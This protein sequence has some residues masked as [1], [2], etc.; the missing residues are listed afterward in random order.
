METPFDEFIGFGGAI[1]ERQARLGGKPWIYGNLRLRSHDAGQA[2]TLHLPARQMDA[3]GQRR[4]LFPR[5][6]SVAPAPER[7]RGRLPAPRAERQDGHRERQVSHAGFGRMK[8]ADQTEQPH[9]RQDCNRDHHPHTHSHFLSPT[10]HR[11]SCCSAWLNIFAAPQLGPSSEATALPQ[12]RLLACGFDELLL[13]SLRRF[14]RT[15]T[16]WIVLFCSQSSDFH[17]AVSL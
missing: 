4:G 17:G 6:P 14:N 1:V 8:L 2:P 12:R 13:K 3:P 5:A 16:T 9:G 10:T 11:R 15:A 7:R